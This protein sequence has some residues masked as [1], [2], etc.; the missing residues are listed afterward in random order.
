M[1]GRSSTV[2][3]T[4]PDLPRGGRCSLGV[5]KA[6]YFTRSQ[7]RSSR[8]AVGALAKDRLEN[9]YRE[10]YALLRFFRAA[11]GEAG[12]L[13]ARLRDRWF[14]SAWAAIST[15]SGCSAAGAIAALRSGNFCF[16][17]SSGSNRSPIFSKRDMTFGASNTSKPASFFLSA[18]STSSQLTGVDAVGC[19]LARREYT[20]TV[21]LCSSFW[22]QSTKTLPVRRLF[23][24][25]ETTCCGC[26]CSNN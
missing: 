17:S 3:P 26:S 23:F 5:L 9:E 11:V 14:S 15:R 20:A 2:V 1:K 12:V 10:D 22:L 18:R 16:N 6:R 24:M 4:G 25:S 13:R 8:V 19:S 21:V 7:R